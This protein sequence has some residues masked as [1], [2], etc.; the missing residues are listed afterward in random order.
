MIAYEGRGQ[1]GPPLLLVHAFPLDRG[2][3]RG[4]LDGLAAHA[5]VVA[6]D[7]PGFGATPPA[8][9]GQRALTMDAMAD[10]VVAV[11]ESLGMDRFICAGLSMGGYVALA[12]ARRHRAH[13]MGLALL[14]TRAE[15]DSPEARKSRHE[16]ADRVLAEGVGFL[17][18]R[19]L[20][21]LLAPRTLAERADL[22][23][24]AE[25]MMRRSTP[26]G[27]ASALR[28]LA[29]RRD[30][31][32]DCAKIDCPTLVVVGA[33]DVITPPPLAR[34]LAQAIPGAQ[35]AVI[36]NAGHLAAYEQPEATNVALRKLIRKVGARSG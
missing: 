32:P 5:R 12:L 26:A 22:A 36:P 11:A 31:R 27:V 29:E 9:S 28:G 13:L 14:D 17:A 7:L 34:A 23:A 6:I 15:P 10:H 18:Q 19:Q 35:L 16:D 3:W 24:G 8:L 4:Q 21:K 25:L 20:P 2:M 30:A 33:E 1:S